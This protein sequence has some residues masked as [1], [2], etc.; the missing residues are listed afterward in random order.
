[1]AAT[2]RFMTEKQIFGKK[3]SLESPEPPAGWKVTEMKCATGDEYACAIAIT[4]FHAAAACRRSRRASL[5]LAMPVSSSASLCSASSIDAYSSRGAP[6][7]PDRIQTTRRPTR[8]ASSIADVMVSS[9]VSVE[10]E[11]SRAGTTPRPCGRRSAT[12]PHSRPTRR[13]CCSRRARRRRSGRRPTAGNGRGR[14]A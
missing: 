4:T 2:R 5:T 10:E 11:A 14:R 7:V 1:M 3:R 12:G 6:G 8:A 13:Q 9:G